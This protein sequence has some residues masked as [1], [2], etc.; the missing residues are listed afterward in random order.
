M[1]IAQRLFFFNISEACGIARAPKFVQYI[2]KGRCSA[3]QVRC[4]AYRRCPCG[5]D[6]FLS[7]RP[8][9][10]RR[11]MIS[12]FSVALSAR[13]ALQEARWASSTTTAVV[14]GFLTALC[15]SVARPLQFKFLRS[16]ARLP[17]WRMPSR[18]SS[19][20]F[21]FCSA[22][23]AAVPVDAALMSGKTVIRLP[24]S[25]RV[26]RRTALPLARSG[27]AAAAWGCVALNTASAHRRP[28]MVHQDLVSGAT[29]TFSEACQ[30]PGLFSSPASVAE[31]TAEMLVRVD[32]RA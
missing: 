17:A 12:Y 4:P 16:P 25:S 20:S 13:R 18:C 29:V 9:A 8:A 1:A 15:R 6:S 14:L 23:T 22:L 7:N 26:L 11:S 30:H 31:H 27:R 19:S 28:V 5:G 32:R 3:A 24:A 2:L 21:R 10:L